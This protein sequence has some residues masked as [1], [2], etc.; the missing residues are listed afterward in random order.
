VECRFF[1]GFELGLG[2]ANADRLYFIVTRP[3]HDAGY[4]PT[5]LGLN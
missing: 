5:S 3:H 2:Q 4:P 1:V